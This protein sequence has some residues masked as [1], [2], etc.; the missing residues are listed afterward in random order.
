M[1]DSIKIHDTV[2]TRSGKTDRTVVGIRPRTPAESFDAAMEKFNAGRGVRP[3]E[4]D[5]IVT[6][7][8]RNGKPFGP[9]L[10]SA[11]SDLTLVAS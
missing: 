6:R 11:A 2:R 7:A 8:L 10:T 3:L 1:M 4:Y 9:E 5:L